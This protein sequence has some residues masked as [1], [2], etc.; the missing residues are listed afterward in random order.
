MQT[1]EYL[2]LYQEVIYG[3]QQIFTKERAAVDYDYEC[4]TN[5]G[6]PTEVLLCL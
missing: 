4:T 5:L 3:F 1:D 6:S 2:K